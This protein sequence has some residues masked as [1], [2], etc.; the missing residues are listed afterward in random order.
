M[1]E[2][3]FWSESDWGFC[4]SDCTYSTFTTPGHCQTDISCNITIPNGWEIVFWPKDNVIIWAGMNPYIAHSLWKPYIKNLSDYDLYFDELCA[5]KNYWTTLIGTGDCKYLW[6]I[7]SWETKYLS[8]T[9]NFIWSMITSWNYGD[10]R[11]VTTIKHEGIRYDNAY[12]R[13]PLD[14][15]VSKSSV[16]TVW[17]WT[18]YLANSSKIW[19][20]SDVANNW[21]LDPNTNKN[22]VWVWVSTWDISSYSNEITDAWSVS[23]V[24]LEWDNILDSFNKVSDTS[25]T[26]IWDTTLLSEFENYNGIDNV[27]ILRNKNFVINSNIFS[28]LNGSRTY[29]IENWDLVI[30]SN[31]TFSDN[32]AFVVKWWDIRINKSVTNIDWT[33]ITILKDWLG[34]SFIWTEWNTTEVLVVNGSLYWNINELISTRTYVKENIFNQIDV[35]T[36][37]SFGSSL[38]RR[39]AP[40]I[41]T[42]I[43]EYLMSEKVAQ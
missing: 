34:W 31:I 37:V 30:N 11:L 39:P 10:N 8:Y 4:N 26:T 40:L 13:A 35:W 27:F 21:E 24:D 18:S 9:P 22:F 17:G 12:F 38:F 2:C 16:A 19:N 41:S 28:T 14:V 15:R 33:Y 1:E 20:I 32:I 36:I 23:N 43:N 29:V 5:V 42:F 7:R 6:I 3:D 25:G